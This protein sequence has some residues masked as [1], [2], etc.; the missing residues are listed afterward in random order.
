MTLDFARRCADRLLERMGSVCVRVEVA[1]SIRRRRPVVGDIDLVAVPIMS[2]SRDLFGTLGPEVN[3][4]AE[5]IRNWCTEGCWTLAKD[6]PSY[7]VWIAKGIQVDLWWATEET[8]GTLLLCRTGSAQHNIWLCERAKAAGGKWNPHHGLYLPGRS[9]L[10]KTETEIYQALGLPF[11]D[12][13]TQR[14]PHA[15]REFDRLPLA[16]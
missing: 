6:G 3:K 10:A 16:A 8:F 4:S 14:D 11:L 1:G 13:E 9:V 2:R 15:Y 12:P 5:A 7:M